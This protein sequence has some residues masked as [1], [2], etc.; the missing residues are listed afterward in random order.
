M[1]YIFD[2]TF[3]Q[4]LAI[5]T[6]A[7]GVDLM[8]PTRIA[9]MLIL[10][11]LLV[12]VSLAERR[13]QWTGK[14]G[15]RPGESSSSLIAESVKVVYIKQ[16]PH[17]QYSVTNI[18]AD[19]VPALGVTMN[20]YDS[21]GNLSGSQKWALNSNLRKGD[22]SSSILA[23]GLKLRPSSRVEV[24][25]AA[26]ASLQQGCPSSYCNECTTNAMRACGE[27]GV[28]TFACTVG[29]T[30]SCEFTC[31]EPGKKAPVRE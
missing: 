4:V 20:V 5:T 19:I 17:L 7:E 11:F 13:S 22:S 24:E 27:R 23:T 1:G 29:D 3:L 31:R 8:K 25:F 28:A 9:T 21:Q 15:I 6:H 14:V 26:L 2:S 12:G 10:S 30:C 18:A 16:Q